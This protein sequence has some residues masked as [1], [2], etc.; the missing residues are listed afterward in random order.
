MSAPRRAPAALG[1]RGRRFWATT[2]GTFDLSDAEAE[3]LAECCR[4]LDEIDALRRSVEQDG[5]TVRGSTGQPR[6]HPA[7]AEVRQHRLALGRLLSQLDLPDEDGGVVSPMR[8]R[9]RRGHAARWGGA[10]RGTA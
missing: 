9:S 6:V 5:T 8:A 10:A 1:A 3:L 7:L 2:L 4:L